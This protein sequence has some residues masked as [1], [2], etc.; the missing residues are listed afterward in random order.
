MVKK[1]VLCLPLFVLAGWLL[2]PLALPAAPPVAPEPADL[3]GAEE[4]DPLA[5]MRDPAFEKYV[6][7]QDIHDALVDQDPVAL[8][9]QALKLA[10][11]EKG[12]KRKH[13]FVVSSDKLLLI[14]I[15]F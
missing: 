1:V 2:A 3:P 4:P 7:I 13:K 15:N 8:T 11:G 14:A 5:D 10:E 9:R 12:L 6:D